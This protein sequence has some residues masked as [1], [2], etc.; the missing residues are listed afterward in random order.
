MADKEQ[1]RL[2]ELA[3]KMLQGKISA[4]EKAELNQWLARSD[5]SPIE[6]PE[7]AGQ[8]DDQLEALLFQKIQERIRPQKVIRPLWPRIAA[9]ASI[10]IFLSVGAYYVFHKQVP[11]QIALIQKQDIAPGRNQATL[12]LANGQKIILRKGL[13]G[14]L[15]RQGNTVIR[16]NGGSAIAYVPGQ[17]DAKI[18]YNTLTTAKGEMSPYPLILPDGSKIWLNSQSSITFPTAFSG[19]ERLVKIT[20]E[21]YLEVV[22]KADQ[23]FRVAV[24]GQTIEDRG[25]HFNIN[26]YDDEPVINTTL[27]EGSIKI[28]VG[29]KTAVL[30][31]GQQAS[32]VNGSSLINVK[33]AD[34]DQ[35]VAWKN[36]FFQFNDADIQTVM[37]QLS[38]WYDV[39]VQ[40]EGKVPSFDFSGEMER[41]LNASQ[42]LKLLSKKVHFRIEGKKIIVTPN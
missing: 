30:K 10:L 8:N 28:S 41:S 3:H 17:V 21:A 16:V 12:T 14:Q 27:L 20:G 4:E 1:R 9:A 39:D 36:G 5:D 34:V 37:R 18:E 33:S 6:V 2:Q 26:A 19:K 25:T 22:H 15:A 35:A 31:P 29:T 7:M 24:K 13:S 32:T 38:R 42:V 11:P 23:P 40:Y